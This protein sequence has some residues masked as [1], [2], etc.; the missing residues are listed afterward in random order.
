MPPSAARPPPRRHDSLEA[1][2]ELLGQGDR[3]ESETAKK[4]KDECEGE[5]VDPVFD[6]IEEEANEDG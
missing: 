4:G 2:V 6:P 5:V 1:V 3:D